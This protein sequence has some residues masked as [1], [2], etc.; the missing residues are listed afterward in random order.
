M[1]GGE[2]IRHGFFYREIDFGNAN[3]LDKFPKD[4][5]EWKEEETEADLAV[6]YYLDGGLIE[7]YFKGGIA[8]SKMKMI[9]GRIVVSYFMD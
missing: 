7:E 6:D 8:D 9:I 1:S 2:A 4:E 5:T 3:M